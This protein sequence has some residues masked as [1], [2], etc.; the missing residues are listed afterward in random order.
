MNQAGLSLLLN[1]ASCGLLQMPA[2][3]GEVLEHILQAGLRA[4]DHGHLQPFRFLLAEGSGLNRLGTL[5]ADSAR[6]DGAGEDVVERATQMPLRAPLVITVVAKVTPHNK[7]PD[8]EQHLAAGCAVMAMQ[9]AAQ[10]QGF[11]GIWRSGPLMYSRK[12]HEL[13]GLAEQDQIVGFLYLG[14]PATTLREPSFVNSAE[15]VRWV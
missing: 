13:L 8:F 10:A 2:P 15:F 11:G 5:L 12:L 1:R 9:M 7:V 4:P 14:T 3:S 6:A